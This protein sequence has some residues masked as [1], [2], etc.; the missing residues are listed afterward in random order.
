MTPS[1][2]SPVSRRR[3]VTAALAAGLAPA[4]SRAADEPEPEA[5]EIQN[6][7]KM[8]YVRQ[9]MALKGVLRSEDD[10]EVPFKLD[11]Q[12]STIRFVFAGPPQIINLDL[13]DKGFQ[14][15]EVV[16]GS[17]AAVSAK[18]Y[19]EKVR[20]T[21]ITYEDLSLRFLYWPNPVRLENQTV[22]HRTC[23][24]LRLINPDASGAYGTAFLW[25]DKGSGGLMR[26]QGYDRQG[27]LIKQHEV[28]SGM[29][30]E[31]GM[32]LKQLRVE[33]MDPATRKVIGRTYLELEKE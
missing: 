7:V 22:K 4:W 2:H 15:Y 27:K 14:L 11:M 26:M 32:M 5:D 24:Q 9:N 21:D 23:W 25:V 3:F 1:V 12:Q 20:D 16:K 13:N 31:G 17:K 6:L 29:K 28:I 18:K 30:V 19:A 10:R 8:S 33:S